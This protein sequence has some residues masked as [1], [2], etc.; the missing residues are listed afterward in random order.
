MAEKEKASGKLT[1]W[2]YSKNPHVLRDGPNGEKRSLPVGG[3]IE[4]LDDKEFE[5]LKKYPGFRTSAMVAPGMSATI[6][7]LESKI[8]DQK[9]EIA[10]L[11][12]AND[13][14]KRKD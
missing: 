9:A 10:E 3:S 12:K 7:Q 13:K 14:Y 6:D 1:L 2:N 4:A 11:K 5:Q 8:E